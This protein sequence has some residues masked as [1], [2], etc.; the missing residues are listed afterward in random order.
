MGLSDFFSG[1][2]GFANTAYNLFTN[3]RD[4]DY[5]KAIQQKIFDREDTAVQRRVEDLKAAGLNPALANGSAAGAGSVVSRSN[6][7]DVNMG[8]ALDMIQAA[9]Q[10]KQQKQ[11]TENLEKE[12]EYLS[13]QTAKFQQDWAFDRVN[14]LAGLGFNPRI[15]FDKSGKIVVEA[16]H[17]SN[18]FYDTPLGELF[19]YNL[20][21]QR[22]S[23]DILQKD[24]NYYTADKITGYLSALLPNI[25]FSFGKKL[26]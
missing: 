16:Q 23:A 14:Q 10:I 18:D 6:T 22:N 15:T 20:Q 24:A 7:N 8:A 11:Q 25:G 4:F 1:L 19:N 3:K 21:N 26:R 5:Q 9:N 13:Y 2:T 12:F 17:R